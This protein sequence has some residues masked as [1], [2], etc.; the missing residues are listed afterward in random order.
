MSADCHLSIERR[1]GGREEG[2]SPRDGPSSLSLPPNERS[3]ERP[4]SEG[5]KGNAEGD[6]A[7]GTGADEMGRLLPPL[8]DIIHDFVTGHVSPHGLSCCVICYIE[9]SGCVEY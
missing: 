1:P 9:T 2:S 5:G 6:A 7:G 8:D 4:Q 3:V